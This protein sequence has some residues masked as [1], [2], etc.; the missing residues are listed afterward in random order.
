MIIY[1]I[2]VQFEASRVSKQKPTLFGYYSIICLLWGIFFNTNLTSVQI[3]L[4]SLTTELRLVHFKINAL[5]AKLTT[6]LKKYHCREN[7]AIEQLS[8]LLT[9]CVDSYPPHCGWSI[10]SQCNQGY[11]ASGTL[12]LS[13]FCRREESSISS[14][15][16][17][18]LT[19]SQVLT[20]V[21][22]RPI[23]NYAAQK[24]EVHFKPYQWWIIL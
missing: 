2:N 5:L 12:V 6:S 8:R 10:E 24:K 16:P 17:S 13:V 7:K 9:P 22:L 18:I 3:L 21:P 4:I 1:N 14:F 11:P 19:F 20:V 15:S 23:E